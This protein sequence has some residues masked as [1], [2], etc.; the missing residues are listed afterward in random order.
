MSECICGISL[1]HLRRGFSLIGCAAF[2]IRRT[3]PDGTWVSAHSGVPSSTTFACYN[4][5]RMSRLWPC[6]ACTHVRQLVVGLLKGGTP[7]H[8]D[9]LPCWLLRRS[10]NY[11]Q[12]PSA[13][14]HQEELEQLELLL[15]PHLTVH[16]ISNS[17]SISNAFVLQ[18][19]Q[20]NDR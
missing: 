20:W 17:C 8:G 6:S 5:G 4:A 1:I 3:P 7:E 11:V 18:A 15:V 10:S 12:A 13:P 2:F 16:L 9:R 14:G 19:H